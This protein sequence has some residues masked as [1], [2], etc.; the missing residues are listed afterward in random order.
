MLFINLDV[1]TF[2]QYYTQW[3]CTTRAQWI[4]HTENRF[5]NYIDNLAI[6]GT[7]FLEITSQ[8]VHYMQIAQRQ[9]GPLH[10]MP[11]TYM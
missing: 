5:T 9:I 2:I 3:L 10:V 1:I 8:Y 6:A 4:F 11:N 7:L